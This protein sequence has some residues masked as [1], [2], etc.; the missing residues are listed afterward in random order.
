MWNQFYCAAGNG[1]R[2]SMKLMGTAKLGDLATSGTD[3]ISGAV[4]ALYAEL[5]AATWATPADVI[6]FYPN[7]VVDADFIRVPLG[8][9]YC[10]DLIANYHAG[11]ILIDFAGPVEKASSIRQLKKRKAV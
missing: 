6:S 5:A 9:R 11:M 8:E 10:V 7:A 4:A 2:F 3:G 1:M